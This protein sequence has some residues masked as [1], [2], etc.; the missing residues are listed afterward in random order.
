MVISISFIDCCGICFSSLF[1]KKHRSFMQTVQSAQSQR[2]FAFL[3]TNALSNSHCH[4]RYGTCLLQ[5]QA[6][7]DFLNKKIKKLISLYIFIREIFDSRP[8]KLRSNYIGLDMLCPLNNKLFFFACGCFIKL[9]KHFK[10][11]KIII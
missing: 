2:C 7:V 6:K 3:R 11:Y 1:I 8:I 5:L 9:I 4:L 10:R